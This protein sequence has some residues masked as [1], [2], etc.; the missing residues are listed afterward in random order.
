VAVHRIARGLDLPLAGD[1]APVIDVGAVSRCVALVAADYPGLKP[2]MRVQAGDE[3]ARGQLLFE[4]KRIPG[5]RHTAPAAGTV[6]AIH[7]GEMRALQ[8]VVIEVARDDGPDRQVEL[9]SFR[10]LPPADLDTAAVTELLVESGLWSALRTRPF[11]RI[12]I[13]GTVPYAIF[14]TAIDTHPHAPSVDAVLGGR[15]DDFAVGVQCVAKLTGGSTFVCKEAGSMVSAPAGERISIEEFAGPHPA[16]TPG[17]H[18]HRLAPVDGERTVWHVGYQDVAAIGRLVTTGRID[19]ERVISLAGPG[20]LRP[21]MLRTRLGAST[22]ALTRDELKPGS[23]RVVSGS[24]L[25]GR[26]ARGEIHGYLGRYHVQIA[27]VPEGGERELFGFIRPGADKFSIWGVV[28]G[29]WARARK[30]ALTT[31]TNGSPRAMVPIGAYERVMPMD[32][33]PTFLLRALL[34]RDIEWAEELGVLELDE[35]DLALCTFVCPGKV[36]YGPLLRDMLTRI[37]KEGEH[38]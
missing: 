32:L 34:A 25:D 28:L 11:S 38:G 13:P 33:M 8:S 5:L 26:T 27:V 20:V 23:Q 37:E 22:D 18:I 19:V 17:L 9:A 35:E 7:R 2:T 14:V 10:A 15:E 6:A 24:A 12:P 21:R 36:E 3:V 29:H 4:D 30:L 16:G 1:P 31:T